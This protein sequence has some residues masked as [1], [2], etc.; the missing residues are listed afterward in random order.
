MLNRN[1]K[2]IFVNVMLHGF[3]IHVSRMMIQM[4]AY[5]R[6]TYNLY[7]YLYVHFGVGRASGEHQ[8]LFVA[9]IVINVA[10]KKFN[11]FVIFITLRIV[12]LLYID[13][14]ACVCVYHQKA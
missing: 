14:S 11:S 13:F 1:N 7:L 4:I 5:P 3:I 8:G 6:C 9:A 2:Y 10:S 12:L